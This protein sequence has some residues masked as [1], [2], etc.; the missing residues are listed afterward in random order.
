[1][2]SWEILLEGGIALV[3]GLTGAGGMLWNLSSK[4]KAAQLE[5][6]EA[7][8]AAARGEKRIDKLEDELDKDRKE[9]ADQWQQFSR[10]L[11]RIE[12]QMNPGMSRPPGGGR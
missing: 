10:T 1:M 8:A 11:G 12:G 6:Q 2:E 9:A 5:A 4:I 7:K 3:G